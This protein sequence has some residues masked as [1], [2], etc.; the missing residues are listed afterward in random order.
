MSAPSWTGSLPLR[1]PAWPRTRPGRLKASW[2]KLAPAR[3]GYVV[4]RR[5]QEPGPGIKI[6]VIV[7]AHI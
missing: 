1:S 4:G 6:S 5:A 3:V 7:I 2:V